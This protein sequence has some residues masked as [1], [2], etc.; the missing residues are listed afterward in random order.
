MSDYPKTDTE[1]N[2]ENIFEQTPK[3]SVNLE[4]NSRGINWKIKVVSG[5]E[6]LMKGLM[7]Q[8]VIIHRALEVEFK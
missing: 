3:S 2:K 6:K 4:K 8:A 7:D 5:E 1:I